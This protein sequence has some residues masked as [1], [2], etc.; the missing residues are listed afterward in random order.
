MEM[1]TEGQRSSSRTEKTGSLGN[2]ILFFALLLSGVAVVFIGRITEQMAARLLFLAIGVGVELAAV[3][4]IALYS[5]F[6]LLPAAPRK[7]S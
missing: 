2:A 3:L 5:R 7:A 1:S 6:R 4:L